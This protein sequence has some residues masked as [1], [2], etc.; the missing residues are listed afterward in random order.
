M[1]DQQGP[2]AIRNPATMCFEVCVML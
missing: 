1:R 2:K